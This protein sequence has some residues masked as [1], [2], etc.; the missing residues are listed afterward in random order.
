MPPL[1]DNDQFIIIQGFRPSFHLPPI[2]PLYRTV[3]PLF[4]CKN[5]YLNQNFIKICSDDVLQTEL[6][7]TNPKTA[8]QKIQDVRQLYAC[9]NFPSG[10][11]ILEQFP[12]KEMD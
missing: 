11:F 7:S 8:P 5:L 10:S 6:D 1:Y 3:F 9:I 12:G 2:L 4:Y